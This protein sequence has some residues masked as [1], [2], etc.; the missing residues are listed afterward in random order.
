MSIQRTGYGI[1][2]AKNTEETQGQVTLIVDFNGQYEA[3]EDALLMILDAWD[4]AMKEIG[5]DPM[6]SHIAFEREGKLQ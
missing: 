3:R 4:D 2:V 5:Y 6:K 1:K